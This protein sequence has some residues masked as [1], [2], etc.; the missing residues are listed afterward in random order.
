[1]EGLRKMRNTMRVVCNP[2]A[3][4]ISYYFK[5]ELGEWYILTGS[6]PLSRN[7]YTSTTIIEKADEIV[8]KLDEIYNRNNK[9]LDIIFEGDE[10]SFNAFVDAIN[11]KLN[12][13]DINCHLGN[14]KVIVTGK[15]G[16]GKTTL[17]EELEKLQGMKFETEE[18][19]NYFL[20]K[21]TN[22]I[23]W[24]EIKGI[25]F[26]FANVEKAYADICEVARNTAGIIVYC[27]DASNRRMEVVEKNFILKL[28]AEF[29]EL[30][31]M[32]VLT[33]C[34]NKRG[35]NEFVDEIEKMTDQIKVVPTLA[36]EFVTDLENEDTHEPIVLQPFG[37]QKLAEYVFERR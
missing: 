2:I 24:Y 37:L 11:R 35:L 10:N 27:I 32:I 13:R 25:D 15:T 8:V 17:I 33:K 22:N 20:Y 21:S 31:G 19:D 1:M 18:H 23:E 4:H 29:P 14:T 3:K 34:V 30:A 12:D 26:G 9:G 28:I 6:S 5:N 16:I 7:Y 36:Q